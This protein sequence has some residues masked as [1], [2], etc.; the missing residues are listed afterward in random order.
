M[1]VSGEFQPYQNDDDVLRDGEDIWSVR[2]QV[3]FFSFFLSQ[4]PLQ[5]FERIVNFE[6]LTASLTFDILWYF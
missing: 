2:A 6:L 1:A 4:T 5:F 3:K